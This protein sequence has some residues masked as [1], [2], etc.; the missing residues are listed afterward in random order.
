M[1]VWRVCICGF[2]GWWGG[3]LAGW[4]LCIDSMEWLL[5]GCC[6]LVVIWRLGLQRLGVDRVGCC[7]GC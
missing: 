1:T 2:V 5:F 4:G 7:F 6:C 3:M